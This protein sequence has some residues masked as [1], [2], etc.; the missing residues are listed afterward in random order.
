MTD[1]FDLHVLHTLPDL[2]YG[3]IL[4]LA[5]FGALMMVAPGLGESQIPAPIRAGL[6]VALAVLLLPLLSPALPPMPAEPLRLGGAVAAELVT[7]LWFGWLVRLVALA[8]PAAANI[9]SF[10][11]GLSSVISPDPMLGQTGALARLFGMVP[12]LLILG[13]GLYIVPLAALAGSYQV[14]HAGAL[15]PAGDASEMMVRGVAASFALAVRLAA[16]FILAGTIWQITLGLLARLVPSLQVY[17]LAMPGQVLGGLLLL[18]VTAPA[19]LAAWM[20]AAS[21]GMS[22]LAP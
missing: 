21:G 15:L 17:L 19:L 18:A 10:M 12:P 11:T 14:V 20:E 1:G 9:A 5:R 3:F 2:A 7:G 13:S 22:P 8:L 16:P 4:L 6:A